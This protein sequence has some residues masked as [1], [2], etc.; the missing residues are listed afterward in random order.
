MP[1]VGSSTTGSCVIEG[2]QPA[3]VTAGTHR[4][5]SA[6]QTLAA[7]L[8]WLPTFGITRVADVTWLDDL[9]I[10]VYQAIRPKSRSLALSQGK[11]LTRDLAR[12]SAIMETLEGRAAES[13]PI[14][15]RGTRAADLDLPYDITTLARFGFE[16]MAER[17]YLDWAPAVELRTGQHTFVPYDVVSLDWS[18]RQRWTPVVFASTS[19]GLASGNTVAE[20]TL[21]GLLE[22]VER[23][24]EAMSDRTEIV[25][26]ETV[27]SMGARLLLEHIDASDS[28]ISL[29]FERNAWGVAVF[30]ASLRN[31]AYP[32]FFGGYGAH[33][34]PDVALC[35]AI[36]EAAQ[37]RATHIAGSRDDMGAGAYRFT[38]FG[39]R[40][41]MPEATVTFAEAVDACTLRSSNDIVE[42][43]RR[44]VAV[45]EP[46]PILV[47]D[48]TLAP[49]IHVAKVVV[50]GL[51]DAKD[52][53]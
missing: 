43:L 51:P 47:T 50:P 17:S 49:G 33:L 28:T 30:G 5:R 52:E 3:V 10:P 32:R 21:H 6:E 53:K 45:L 48:L 20:A 40:E 2:S 35:R 14:A 44:V 39:P 7:L 42:D 9:G 38:H 25:D 24:V 29:K 23:A 27:D 22:V 8:P 1:I 41:P 31:P 36:T 37:S 11:G 15:R 13:V 16:A 19:N 18:L 12:I 4:S 46:Y 26:A 34:D